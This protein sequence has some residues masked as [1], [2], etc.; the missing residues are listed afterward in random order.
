VNRL[1]PSMIAAA[2]GI[3]SLLAQNTAAAKAICFRVARIDVPWSV[4]PDDKLTSSGVYVVD[5]VRRAAI[6]IGSSL[7]SPGS[8]IIWT[9]RAYDF[10]ADAVRQIQCVLLAQYCEIAHCCIAVANRELRR[11]ES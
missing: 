4:C 11:D 8:A 3:L 10:S 1:L 7:R 6:S 2:V 5:R 9:L